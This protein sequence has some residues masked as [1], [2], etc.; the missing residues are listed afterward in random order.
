MRCSLVFKVGGQ[1]L[2]N[3]RM[4]ERHYF[5]DTLIKV[6]FNSLCP[7]RVAVLTPG[8]SVAVLGLQL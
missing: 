7:A 1:E 3:F 4:I 8:L 5:K 2:K 6:L